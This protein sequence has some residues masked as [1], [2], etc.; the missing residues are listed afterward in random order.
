[1]WILLWQLESDDTKISIWKLFLKKK[2]NISR[3]CEQYCSWLH[4]NVLQT[5]LCSQTDP[6]ESLVYDIPR[7]TSTSGPTF[8]LSSRPLNSPHEKNVRGL[9]TGDDSVN[10]LPR[11][12][13]EENVRNYLNI[14][15][16]GNVRNLLNI[17]HED[18][19]RNL[20]N[21]SQEDNVRKYLNTPHEENVRT[22]G[23]SRFFLDFVDSLEANR[24]RWERNSIFYFWGHKENSTQHFSSFHFIKLGD[25]AFHVKTPL[26]QL[27]E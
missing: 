21:I 20:L 10:N 1:M 2:K 12:P 3:R 16:E 13:C 5:I 6:S 27:V 4:F 23:N 15:H 26:W 18:N 9:L 17:S 19:V 25:D 11:P 24:M 8:S 22:Y 7:S 14:R